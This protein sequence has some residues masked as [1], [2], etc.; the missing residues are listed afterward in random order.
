M[1]RE[2]QHRLAMRLY[3]QAMAVVDPVRVKMWSDAE[4]TTSQLRLL[5]VMRAEPGSPLGYLASQLRV[6]PPTASGLVD[7]LVRQDY[8][9]REE[10][11]QDR[12]VVRHRLTERGLRIVGEIEREAADLLDAI[13]SRLSDDELATLIRGLALLSGAAAEM[14]AAPAQGPAR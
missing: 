10:D 14:D 5:F 7:R 3:A 11:A 9:R 2:E 4:L 13:F 8:A 1:P 12:R 6:S